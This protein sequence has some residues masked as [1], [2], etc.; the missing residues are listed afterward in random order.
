MDQIF[1]ENEIDE[2]KVNDIFMQQVWRQIEW[3]FDTIMITKSK[4]D[5]VCCWY[6]Y[7]L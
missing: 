6:V 5:Q 1:L 7:Y 2:E 3:T 4:V